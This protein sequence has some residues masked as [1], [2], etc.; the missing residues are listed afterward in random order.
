MFPWQR[1]LSSGTVQFS[2][3]F[4]FFIKYFYTWKDEAVRIHTLAHIHTCTHAHT[5]T[6]LIF[7]K[8]NMY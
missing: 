4:V 7:K 6:V 5:H 8:T 2:D 1:E 3:V